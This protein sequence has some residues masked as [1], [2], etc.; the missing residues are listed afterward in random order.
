MFDPGEVL[1]LYESPAGYGLITLRICAWGM[2]IYSTVVTLKH[3]QEKVT[4]RAPFE[5]IT[6]V[7]FTAGELLLPVQYMWD[8]VVYSGTGLHT[9]RKHLRRQVD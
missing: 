8:T 5:R 6:S 4:C 2:F 9:V 3:Y 1:Y 7:C